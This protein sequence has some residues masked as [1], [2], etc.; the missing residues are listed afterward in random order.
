VRCINVHR[1]DHFFRIPRTEIEACHVRV[2]ENCFPFERASAGVISQSIRASRRHLF[3]D[4]DRR[5][6]SDD[7]RL[8]RHSRQSSYYLLPS[9]ARCINRIRGW[10]HLFLFVTGIVRGV[11]ATTIYLYHLTAFTKEWIIKDFPSEKIC[12]VSSNQI[13]S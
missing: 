3:Y 10:L 11:H 2:H 5:Y 8:K 13:P 12:N 7:N 6:W 9:R 1:V 4:H